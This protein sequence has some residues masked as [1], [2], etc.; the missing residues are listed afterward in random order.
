MLDIEVV[1]IVE[2]GLDFVGRRGSDILVGSSSRSWLSDSNV[3]H[4]RVMME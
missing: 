4:D 3:R 1:H 2:D